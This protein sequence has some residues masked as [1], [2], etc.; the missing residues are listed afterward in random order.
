MPSNYTP[1][2]PPALAEPFCAFPSDALV[3]LVRFTA[4]APYWESAGAALNLSGGDL[5]VQADEAHAKAVADRL[6]ALRVEL[7]R[8][9]RLRATVVSLPLASIPE[10]LGGL[11]DGA[12]LLLDGGKAVLARA[13]ATIVDRGGVRCR[14][15][16]RSVS[17]GGNEVVYVADYDVEIA[18]AANIGN[19]ITQAVLAGFSL[20]AACRPAAGG[21]AVACDL[22]LDRSTW[23]ASRDVRTQHGDIECPTLGIS[24]LRGSTLV[25]LGTLRIVGAT[26]ENGIVTLTILSANAD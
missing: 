3:N 18:Q 15:S 4:D 7:G 17:V 12:T 26:L 10:Y 25:P 21:A 6:D 16:Q 2:E 24:R 13:G 20:D 19:P 22:R 11:D 5:H 1:P 8:P 14:P 23:N 9:T